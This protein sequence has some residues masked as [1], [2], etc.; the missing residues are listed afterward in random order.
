MLRGCE[1]EERAQQDPLPK[2]TVDQQQEGSLYGGHRGEPGFAEK[3]LGRKQF[4]PPKEKASDNRP[5]AA[6]GQLGEHLTQDDAEA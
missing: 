1:R 6:E 5:G 3:S 2:P 4:Q